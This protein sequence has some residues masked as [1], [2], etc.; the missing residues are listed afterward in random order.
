MSSKTIRIIT[1]YRTDNSIFDI[2]EVKL[3][4]RKDGSFTSKVQRV[5]DRAIKF[6]YCGY[7]VAIK[8]K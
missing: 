4:Y 5:F 1:R 3:E 7:R 2:Q 6:A 8:V